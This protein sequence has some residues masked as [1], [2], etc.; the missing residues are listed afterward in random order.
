[1]S[2]NLV[3][4]KFQSG[5]SFQD[6]YLRIPHHYEVHACH[7]ANTCRTGN[8]HPVWKLSARPNGEAA[9]IRTLPVETK[10]KCIEWEVVGHFRFPFP[11]SGRWDSATYMVYKKP[12]F[13]PFRSPSYFVSVLPDTTS[14][15]LYNLQ[16][17]HGRRANQNS[18]R[19]K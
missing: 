6:M 1:M 17:E 12:F 10:W 5:S 11:R 4:C 13:S 18:P 19:G 7:T 15:C 16:A 3:S 8:V 9:K 2:A 14:P